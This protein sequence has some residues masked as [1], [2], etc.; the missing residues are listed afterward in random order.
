MFSDMNAARRKKLLETIELLK[1]RRQQL[2]EISTLVKEK[3]GGFPET[4]EFDAIREHYSDA[5]DALDEAESMLGGM[6]EDTEFD[7]NLPT[8]VAQSSSI[9]EALA[10]NETPVKKDQTY[11]PSSA[12]VGKPESKKGITASQVFV[13]IGMGIFFVPI[14]YLLFSIG[15][16]NFDEFLGML[17]TIIGVMFMASPL[18]AFIPGLAEVSS[19]SSGSSFGSYASY[20]DTDSGKIPGAKHGSLFSDSSSNDEKIRREIYARQDE[21]LSI[22]EDMIQMHSTNPDADLESHY[23]WEHKIDYDQDGYDDD[24]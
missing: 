6:I 22:L 15:I 11:T 20:S 2:Q 12:Q 7:L 18:L 9:N 4:E 14:G 17:F 23:G 3:E 10:K 21:D 16:E 13:A 8:A 5:C 1:E 19:H 24:Y